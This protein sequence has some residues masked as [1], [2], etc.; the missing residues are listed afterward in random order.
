MVFLAAAIKSD[1]KSTCR[2]L[3]ASIHTFPPLGRPARVAP[4]NAQLTIGP[5]RL[6]HTTV[7]WIDSVGSTVG[8]V[9]TPA[10][11]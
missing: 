1:F 10:L 8:K 2:N 5:E 3:R 11:K 9:N 4:L 6:L 7:G